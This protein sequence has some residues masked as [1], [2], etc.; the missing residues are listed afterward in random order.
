LREGHYQLA[1]ESARVAEAEAEKAFFEPSMVGQVYFPDEHKVAVYV[2]LLGPMAVPLVMSA[3]KEL[4]NW[5]QG[6]KIK[7]L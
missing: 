6:R 3:L 1:L 2:P 7:T 5:R 4:K